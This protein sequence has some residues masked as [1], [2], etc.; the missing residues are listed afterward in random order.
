[1]N[2]HSD[3]KASG[4]F[5]ELLDRIGQHKHL[6]VPLAILLLLAVLV[7]PLPPAILDVLIAANIAQDAAYR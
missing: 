7:V 1:M 4:G 6:I 3:V 5:G 2:A